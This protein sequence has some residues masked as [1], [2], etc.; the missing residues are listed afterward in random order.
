MY[1]VTN[2]DGA[3]SRIVIVHGGTEPSKLTIKSIP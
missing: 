1:K 2:A 3:I